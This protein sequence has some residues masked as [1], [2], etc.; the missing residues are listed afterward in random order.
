MDSLP[1][2]NSYL[3]QGSCCC[4]C[5]KTIAADQYCVVNT[6]EGIKVI[7]TYCLKDL[8]VGGCMAQIEVLWR[9]Q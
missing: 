1:Y 7:H 6:P 9:P 2:F 3:K 4:I 5:S 8:P